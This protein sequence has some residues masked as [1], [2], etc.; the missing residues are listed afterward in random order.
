MLQLPSRGPNVNWWRRRV[1]AHVLAAHNVN[2]VSDVV[3]R[4]SANV[5]VE[6]N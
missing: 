2:W 5:V 4:R 6:V 1:K 3:G